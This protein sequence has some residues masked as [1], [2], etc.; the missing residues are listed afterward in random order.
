MKTV[1]DG[2]SKFTNVWFFR[3]KDDTAEPFIKYLVDIA[4]RKVEMVRSN[5]RGE[6]EGEFGTLCTRI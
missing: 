4:P 2:Y 6:F 5:G 3:I 1:T